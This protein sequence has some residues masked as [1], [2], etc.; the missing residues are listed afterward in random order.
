M[1]PLIRYQ[2]STV[3]CSQRVIRWHTLLADL[4]IVDR[5][6]CLASRT[7]PTIHLPDRDR[8]VPTLHLHICYGN[9]SE[10]SAFEYYVRPR[11]CILHKILLLS[12]RSID[13][14]SCTILYSPFYHP[15]LLSKHMAKF[16]EQPGNGE[17]R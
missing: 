11:A 17:E 4:A 9:D 6:G 15:A 2:S 12:Q 16:K 14:N 3:Q 13:W 7:Q 5:A 1:L 8:S 10:Y